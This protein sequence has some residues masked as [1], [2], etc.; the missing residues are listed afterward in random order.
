MAPH[1]VVSAAGC[2]HEIKKIFEM[3]LLDLAV[4]V[5]DDIGFRNTSFKTYIL[6]SVQ[7]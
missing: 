1:K 7:I 3:F 2:V 6:F 5:I 4:R